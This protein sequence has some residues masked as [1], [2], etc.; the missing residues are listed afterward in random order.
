MSDKISKIC[1]I[2]LAIGFGYLFVKHFNYR[3]EIKDNRSETICKY[4]F[5]KQFPRSTEAYVK[6]CV[7][8]KLY[9]NSPGGCP[10][11]S[12]SALNKYYLVDY[13]AIDPNKIIVDFSKEI[14]DSIL[15][16]ELESKLEFKYWL[17]H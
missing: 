6:Y 10:E 8:G 13:S 17:D 3:K 14:K 16:K 7:D 11:N 15:I 4:T 1:L 2:I 12:E 5:C 9:R